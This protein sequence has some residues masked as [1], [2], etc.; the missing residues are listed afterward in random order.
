MPLSPITLFVYNRPE[1]TKRTVEALLKNELASQCELFI[2]SDAPKNEQAKKD[3]QKVREYIKT[4]SGFKT[5]TVIERENNFGLAK[6][7]ITGVTD[8]VNKH[9]KV[10]VLE[11]DLI[12]SP[13]FLKYMNGALDFYEHEEKVIS[14]H[15]YIYPVSEEMPETFFIKG[16]DCWGWA[17]W[18]RGWDLFEADG[19]K[20]L[21]ELKA[22]N[23]TKSFDLGGYPYTQMLQAQIN[24]LN[25]SW[26]IRWYASA[27]LRDKLTL[28]PGKSL[29]SNLGFDDSGTHTGSTNAFKTALTEKPIT[30]GQ[31]PISENLSALNLIKKYFNSPKMRLLSLS[32]KLKYYFKLLKKYV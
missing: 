30:I 2:F 6:S 14:I 1:H 19:Q 3:V 8:I 29:I 10:I 23:L 27:F 11:D 5:V 24:G 7:I 17:T 9:G 4:I 22:K 31:I 26:A 18:K 13:Y 21:D 15:G 32:I 16:A 20:L 25:S 28:Y 12:A